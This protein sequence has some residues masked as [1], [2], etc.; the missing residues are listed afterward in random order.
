MDVHE[1]L[2]DTAGLPSVLLNPCAKSLVGVP[3]VFDI[4][5]R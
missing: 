1:V 4:V 2:A 5:T 3:V